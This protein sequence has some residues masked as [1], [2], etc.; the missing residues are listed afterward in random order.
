VTDR[1]AVAREPR[2]P[3]WQVALVLLLADREAEV[4]ARVKAVRALA[5]L[6]REERHDVVAPSDGADA[7]AHGLHDARAFVPQ[8]R[9]RVAR[10][11]GA[12]SGVEVGVADT[13]GD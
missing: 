5:A 13:A 6:R 3:V 1:L 9:R 8:H 4:R 7:L 10:W 11:V 12:R 2:G